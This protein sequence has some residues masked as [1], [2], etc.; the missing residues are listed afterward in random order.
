MRNL[1]KSFKF[2]NFSFYILCFFFLCNYHQRIVQIYT[3]HVSSKYQ[4]RQKQLICNLN[5]KYRL[6]KIMTKRKIKS[7]HETTKK[8]NH[9]FLHKYLVTIVMEM[10]N[11]CCTLSIEIAPLYAMIYNAIVSFL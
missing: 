3:I 7:H 8:K 1:F 6:I 2:S 11:N 4:L 5:I 10:I 9:F